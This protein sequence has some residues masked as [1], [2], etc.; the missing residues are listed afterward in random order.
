[1]EEYMSKNG[2]PIQAPEY[3]IPVTFDSR[4]LVITDYD[5]GG[6]L[7]LDRE[8]QIEALEFLLDCLIELPKNI[9]IAKKQNYKE[10]R[11]K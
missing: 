1:M 9:E 7:K 8:K 6:F 11:K 3:G 10:W 5:W 4:A 2:I